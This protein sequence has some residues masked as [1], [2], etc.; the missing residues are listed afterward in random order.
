MAGNSMEKNG[1][2]NKK[3]YKIQREK[4]ISKL[5]GILKENKLK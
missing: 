4:F 1:K 2:K 3:N 5:Q